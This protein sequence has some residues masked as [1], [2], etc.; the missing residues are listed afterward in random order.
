MFSFVSG[1]FSHIC[2]LSVLPT[3]PVSLSEVRRANPLDSS[4]SAE[5]ATGVGRGGNQS[6][7]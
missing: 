7:G 1:V 3:L 4:G 6:H 5:R 2:V